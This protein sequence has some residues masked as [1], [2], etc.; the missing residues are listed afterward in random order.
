MTI[1]I[2]GRRSYVRM[3]DDATGIA[4]YDADGQAD[5]AEF[6]EIWAP[7]S[8]RRAG[9]STQPV[10]VSRA[11]VQAPT[12]WP[13]PTTEQP[14]MDTLMEWQSLMEIVRRQTGAAQLSRTASVRMGIHPGY[15][16]WV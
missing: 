5:L 16:G 14:D 6:A 8:R 4:S 1:R 3:T 10:R 15:C 12:L 9:W 13:E 7:I 2:G 11:R